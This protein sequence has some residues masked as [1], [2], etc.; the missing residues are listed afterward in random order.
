M[1]DPGRSRRAG[2][3]GGTSAERRDFYDVLGVPRGASGEEIQRAYRTLARRSHPDVNKAPGAEERFKEVTEA[4]DT[5]SNPDSRRRYDRFGASWRQVPE[6]FD[7]GPQ[8]WARAGGRSSGGPSPGGPSSGGPWS[9]GPPHGGR[10][11]VEPGE[12]PA[13]A[14]FGRAPGGSAYAGG[15]DLEDLLGSLFGGQVSDGF[16]RGAVPGADSEA[17]ITVSVEEAFHGGQRRIN[18][19]GP[20]GRPR[21]L[22]VTIPAGVVDGQR[23]RLAGQGA[24]GAR[25]GAAGDLYLVVHLAPHPRYRVNGRDIAV[26]LPVAP[27]EAALGATVSI[28]VETGTFQVKVPPGTSSGR[29]LRLRG[30]GLPNPRGTPGDLYA[31]VRIVVPPKLSRRER[32]LFEELAKVSSFDPRGGS[33]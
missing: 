5:L 26:D 25:G 8:R 27:W 4:Y 13:D 18:L 28:E 22:D 7:A 23:I 31:E 15:V 32:Q 21:Q 29:R 33:R 10:V 12:D 9:G 14:P 30:Q 1:A 2:G 6:D 11:R 24:G 17:E 19:P 16:G 3:A 20:G